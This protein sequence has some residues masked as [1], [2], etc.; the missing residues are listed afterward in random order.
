MKKIV[1]VNSKGLRIG[2]DHPNAKLTDAEVQTLLM[3]RD[4]GKS[5]GWLARVFEISKSQARNYCKA[6]QRCQTPH[7]FKTVHVKD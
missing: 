3:F 4:D 2:Q 7:R 1:A 5:Y 6:N